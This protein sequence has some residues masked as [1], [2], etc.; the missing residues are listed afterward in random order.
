[1]IYNMNIG[2][3]GDLHGPF[4]TFLQ[5]EDLNDWST[6]CTLIQVNRVHRY[7][8]NKTKLKFLKMDPISGSTCRP[9]VLPYYGHVPKSVLCGPLT[10]GQRLSLWGSSWPLKINLYI[11]AEFFYMYI[12]I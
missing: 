3:Y 5:Y 10:V 1:M 11:R 9:I 8:G 6:H 4:W 7:K 12:T 2:T